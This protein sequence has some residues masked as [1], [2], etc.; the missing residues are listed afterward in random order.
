MLG[1]SGKTED[2]IPL[3]FNRPQYDEHVKTWRWFIH[4]QHSWT[5]T[6]GLHVLDY[7]L[8]RATKE[9]RHAPSK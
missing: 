4:T 8:Y 6:Y 7:Y 5:A 9:L 2:I 1:I 3:L